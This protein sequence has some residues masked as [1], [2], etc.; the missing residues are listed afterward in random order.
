M[1]ALVFR[2]MVLHSVE[3]CLRHM[4]SAC[5]QG[6]T[7][8]ARC[9]NCWAG[10]A[11]A[12]AER[13]GAAAPQMAGEP[14]GCL[15][16]C[17]TRAESPTVLSS[18]LG[19]PRFGNSAVLLK[20]CLCPSQPL[21]AAYPNKHEHACPALPPQLRLPF[22]HDDLWGGARV[23]LQ[24][25]PP[26]AEWGGGAAVPRWAPRPPASGSAPLFVF[27]LLRH[28]ALTASQC[29]ASA[30][31]APKAHPAQWAPHARCCSHGWPAWLPPPP[32]RRTGGVREAY[33]R[34]GEEYQLFW[35]E[36]SGEGPAGWAK[37]G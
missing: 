3:A 25:A 22:V 15:C 24:H 27:I 14:G 30:P 17:S 2:A 6:V 28:P 23:C 16:A 33:K 32:P 11:A 7:A 8:R 12:A 5:L 20:P 18:A 37:G 35:P 13:A 4:P 9:S 29:T 34:Q 26:A 1:R 36:K 21:A 31:A 10:V 19:L